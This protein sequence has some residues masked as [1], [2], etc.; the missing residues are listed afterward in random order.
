[1]NIT[2]KVLYNTLQEM[3]EKKS[4]QSVREVYIGDQLVKL[5]FH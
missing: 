4:I 1:M 5:F 3:Q 2:Q